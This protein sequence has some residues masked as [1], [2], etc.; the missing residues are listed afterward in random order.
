MTTWLLDTN[1][2]S[3]LRKAKGGKADKNVTAWAES[4]SAT[5]LFLSAITI[6]ELEP[7]VLQI[8][9]RDGGFSAAKRRDFTVHGVE[10]LDVAADQHE[11]RAMARGGQ[12]HGAADA[13]TG[14]ADRDDASLQEIRR[15]LV[16][17]KGQTLVQKAIFGVVNSIV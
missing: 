5:S 2:V 4:V 15:R 14:A 13:G 8:E 3:E 16:L 12:R 1:I 6:L 7:G 9:R 17:E 11:L 10:S